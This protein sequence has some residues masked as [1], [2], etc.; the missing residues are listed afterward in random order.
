MFLN[1]I[2]AFN[3]CLLLLT[4]ST[5]LQ[6]NCVTKNVR[7]M[8]EKWAKSGKKCQKVAKN[9]KKYRTETEAALVQVPSGAICSSQINTLK[10]NGSQTG[11][12]D[13]MFSNQKSQFG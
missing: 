5:V 4:L 11:L 1:K 10:L 8:A 12:P 13:G 6:L 2:E 9:G 7:R 3:N